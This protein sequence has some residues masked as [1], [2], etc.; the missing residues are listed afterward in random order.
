MIVTYVIY[1]ALAFA[2]IGTI[3][4]FV[5]IYNG[6]VTVRNN[7]GKAWSNIDVL[8]KQRHDEIP[9]LV[10]T[11]ENYMTYEKSTLSK[12]VE[13]RQ[14][15]V[16]AQGVG[17]KAIKE[18]ELGTALRQLFALSEKYPD[19][20]AQSSF[21]QLQSRITGLE[22]AISERREFYNESVNN[23]NIQIQSFPDMLI[24]RLMGLGRQDMFKIEESHRQDVSVGM[25]IP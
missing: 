21:Q 1:G 23:Y 24:A 6:L 4:Y 20:K 22:T 18:G 13:L 11:C 17:D 9:K 19:L 15:A 12:I 14:Q 8:L 25:N 10:K 16:G 2:A 7:F 5:T 3:G